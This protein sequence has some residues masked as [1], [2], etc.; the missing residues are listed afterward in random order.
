MLIGI[1]VGAMITGRSGATSS[2]EPPDAGFIAA[3]IAKINLISP[4]TFASLL[5]SGTN[6][7]LHLDRMVNLDLSQR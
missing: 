6:L 5:D 7:P 2:T 1:E 4:L 3:R